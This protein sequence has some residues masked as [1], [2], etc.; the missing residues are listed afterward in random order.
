MKDILVHVDSGERARMRIEVAVD[1]AKRYGARLTGLFAQ[2]DS[3][4]T[5][6]VARM[7][8]ESLKKAQAEGE[9]LFNTLTKGVETR[10]WALPHGESNFV[11]AEIMFCSRYFDL[12]VLGQNDSKDATTPDDMVEQTV[13]NCGRP[14]LVLPYLGTYSSVAHRIVIAWNAGREATRAVHDSLDLLKQAKTVSVLSM[15]A[16]DD[17][18]A[19]QS[20][21]PVN[22]LDHLTKQGIAC[23]GE[24]LPDEEIGKMDMLLSRSFDLGADLLVMGA[25]GQYGLSRLRG[26]GTRYVLKHMTLPVLM[27]H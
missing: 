14:V 10:F 1:L 7:A 6:A 13:L 5:A 16:H 24:F 17:S 26:S 21:P 25:H 2:V 27:S 22:I 19:A 12:V 18:G 15:R 11:S 8:S 23:D 20:M 9:I 4:R 3:H